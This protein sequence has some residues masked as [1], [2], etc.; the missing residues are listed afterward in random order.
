MESLV[1][2]LEQEVNTHI[3]WKQ[4]EQTL[5]VVAS[6]KEAQEA[7]IQLVWD[8]GEWPEQGKL[9]LVKEGI[10]VG[11]LMVGKREGECWESYVVEGTAAIPGKGLGTLLYLA[12]LWLFKPLAADRLSVSAQAY[13]VWKKLIS[14]GL[15]AQ[16][17]D[18]I[19]HPKTLPPE[20]DCDVYQDK[21]ELNAAYQL[22]QM[23]AGL[24][25]W[26]QIETKPGWW[27][28]LA[29]QFFSYQYH[30]RQK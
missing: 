29:G 30:R 12:A 22:K 21:P 13:A 3:A 4:M 6:M 23:P 15:E 10:L 17:F 20:D 27:E 18:D 2:N 24:K 7:G 5:P 26:I 1:E 8:K 25:E 9:L 19:K 14:K 11:V 28:K 16:W